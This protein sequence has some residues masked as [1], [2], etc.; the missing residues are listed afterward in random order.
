MSYLDIR[1]LYRYQ[2]KKEIFKK[3]VYDT[4]LRKIH[5]RIETVAKRSEVQCQFQIPQ[6]VM[7]MPLYDPTLCSSY[8]IQRL[9]EEGFIVQYV[10]PNWIFVN[11]AKHLI[12]PF[13]KET[14]KEKQITQQKVNNSI[15]Y[16]PTGKLFN[17]NDYL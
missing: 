16:K 15:E 9:K 8:V 11:W 6:F 2:E 7:G 12:E 4:I 10:H 5:H 3:E 13:I 14:I 1:K 17:V